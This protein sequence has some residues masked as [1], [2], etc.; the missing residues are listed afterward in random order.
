[1]FSG[2]TS[3]SIYFPIASFVILYVL[4]TL[5]LVAFT[6]VLFPSL[7]TIYKRI[8]DASDASFALPSEYTT[9]RVCP[10]YGALISPLSTR[11]GVFS[12]ITV[13]SSAT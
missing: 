6:R 8:T 4:S 1:M 2:T 12:N 10:G 11:Y 3:T 13:L 5:A 9:V 7:S